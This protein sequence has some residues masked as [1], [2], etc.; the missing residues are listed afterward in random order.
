MVEI[1]SGDME[2][3][4][5]LKKDLDLD[6]VLTKYFVHLHLGTLECTVHIPKTK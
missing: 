2:L 1:F 5:F 4:F 6:I 3:F